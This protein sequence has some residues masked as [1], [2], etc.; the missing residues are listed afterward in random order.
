MVDVLLS[1]S[2]VNPKELVAIL[3][4]VPGFNVCDPMCNSIKPVTGS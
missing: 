3:I 2:Q 1:T 4:L